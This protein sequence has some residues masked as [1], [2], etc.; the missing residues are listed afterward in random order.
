MVRNIKTKIKQKDGKSK[1]NTFQKLRKVFYI[2]TKQDNITLFFLPNISTIILAGIN[3]NIEK[4][5]LIEVIRTT[6][7]ALMYFICVKNKNRPAG[8]NATK[9]FF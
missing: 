9:C 7:D 3:N 8:D 2:Y 4:I 6:S 5:D 1:K